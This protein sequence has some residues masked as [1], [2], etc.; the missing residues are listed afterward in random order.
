VIAEESD[1]VVSNAYSKRFIAKRL[2]Y[3]LEQ[4]A[5]YRLEYL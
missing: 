3:I 5:S 1:K 4:S 2:I